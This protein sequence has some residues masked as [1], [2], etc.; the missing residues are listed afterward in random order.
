MQEFEIDGREFVKH[1]GEFQCAFRD[2]RIRIW[3]S[4]GWQ[5]RLTTLSGHHCLPDTFGTPEAAGRAALEYWKD[6]IEA[7]DEADAQDSERDGRDYERDNKLRTE[8]VL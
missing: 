6:E 3:R 2:F 8:D 5:A 4:L 7:S 1:S